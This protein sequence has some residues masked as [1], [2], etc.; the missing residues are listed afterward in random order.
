[1]RIEGSSSIKDEL[2]LKPVKLEADIS[3]TQKVPVE[4]APS[5]GAVEQQPADVLSS[6]QE[7]NF[8]INFDLSFH[9]HKET[10]QLIV[11]ILDPQTNEVIK[12]IPPEEMLKL[13]ENLHK[14]IGLFF[15]KKV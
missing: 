6:L 5:S 12:E 10:N 1:M 9:I 3:K 8:N 7:E 2:A 14:M 4:D 11:Q 15:D 13:A